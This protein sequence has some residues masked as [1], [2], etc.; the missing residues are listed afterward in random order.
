MT[1]IT[2]LRVMQI[3]TIMKYHITCVRKNSISKYW[4]V[5]EK[6]EHLSTVV[7][8]YINTIIMESSIESPQKYKNKI[9]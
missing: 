3:K 8:N 2:N 6:K 9:I 7:E 5:S 1:N 4:Q